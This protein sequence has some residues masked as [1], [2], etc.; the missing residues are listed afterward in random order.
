[1]FALCILKK[2]NEIMLFINVTLKMGFYSEL[3][4]LNGILTVYSCYL[5]CFIIQSICV[6]RWSI[7]KVQEKTGWIHLEKN[8]RQVDFWLK[9]PSCN[10]WKPRGHLGEALCV[11]ALSRSLPFL[12]ICSWPLLETK[13]W[14]WW[15]FFSVWSV[16][17]SY[18][19]VVTACQYL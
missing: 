4:F 8:T 6:T 2:K 7:G 16:L 17:F 1:M 12:T 11:L 10:R 5:S 19:C 9:F 3:M 15:I 14:P 13:Y 18:I